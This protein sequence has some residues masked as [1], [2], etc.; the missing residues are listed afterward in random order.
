MR[1][2]LQQFQFAG[3]LGQCPMSIHFVAINSSTAE[4][5][6]K[7]TKT[8]FCSSRLFKVID[9]DTIKKHVIKAICLCLSATVSTTDKIIAGK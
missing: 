1:E 7:I 3:N 6:K 4:N 8:P 5:R 2:S 9:V